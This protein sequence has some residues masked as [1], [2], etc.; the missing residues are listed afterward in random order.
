MQY[1]TKVNKHVLRLNWM[2]GPPIIKQQVSTG[3]E[4]L[5]PTPYVSEL[6]Q[7]P[8]RPVA[9]FAGELT[10][11]IPKD[12]LGFFLSDQGNVLLVHAEVVKRPAALLLH[13]GNVGV[14]EQREHDAGDAAGLGD[15]DAIVLVLEAKVAKGGA[16]DL[17]NV[18]LIVV[19]THGIDDGGDSALATD[20]GSVVVVAGG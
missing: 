4:K 15:R 9:A 18:L 12:R 14:G 19:D 11:R 10:S 6:L 5:P 8:L 17:L 13:A 7:Q 1:L 2:Q 3:A 16:R 20:A